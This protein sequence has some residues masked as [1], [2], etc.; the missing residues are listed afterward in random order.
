[1]QGSKPQRQCAGV[2]GALAV[3][4]SALFCQGPPANSS[5]EQTS[6]SPEVRLRDYL[7]YS[8][9]PDF[10]RP[11]DA[12]SPEFHE[13]RPSRFSSDGARVTA[14]GIPVLRA[15]SLL[16]PFQVDV[17]STGRYA[18]STLVKQSNRGKFA[19]LTLDREMKVGTHT[20]EF[21]L[22]GKILRD[23]SP[24]FPLF[25]EG[26]AGE[27]IPTE[28]QLEAAATTGTTL[29]GRLPLFRQELRIDGFSASAFSAAEWNSAEKQKK[30]AELLAEV[31]AD[32]GQAAE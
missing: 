15:G 20:V 3:T 4:L 1:L 12:D 18:F 13:M 14:W 8:Q 7:A 16:I 29:E 11:A 23:G 6:V 27:R 5:A 19:V 9:Y 24:A 17:R 2:L 26:I 32:K 25:A 10:S 28:K 31:N 22:F 30:I 21:V